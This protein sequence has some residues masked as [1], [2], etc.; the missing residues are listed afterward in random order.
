MEKAKTL[1]ILGGLGPMAG[2]YFYERVTALTQASCDQEHINVLLSGLADT[3]DRTDFILGKSEDDP[4]PRMVESAKI[5]ER[6]GAEVIAMP[7][8]TAHYFY[9][10]IAGSV[11][12]PMLNIIEETVKLLARKGA[13]KIGLLATEGTVAAGT[14]PTAAAAHGITC[15]VPTKEEQSVLNAIIYQEIKCGK[16]PD[17]RAFYRVAN[18]MLDD[19]CDDLVL[20]CTE[21]SLLERDYHLGDRFVD[22]VDAL[23]RATVLACGKSLA[24]A[25]AGI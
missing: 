1:G 12:V 24:D 14:Y 6:A 15:V 17:L 18:R 10:A 21:L 3:P 2:V 19:G 23:A 7:C 16:R 20:G 13:R 25:E 4:T 9:D 8:N 11:T 5:L 22:T